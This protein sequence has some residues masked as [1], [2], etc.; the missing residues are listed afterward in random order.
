MGTACLLL[1]SCATT[2]GPLAAR[3]GYRDFQQSKT[4][5][6]VYF[7]VN[8]NT[9]ESTA[10][11]FFLT[12]AAQIA[13]KRG[14]PS[15]YIYHLKHSVGSQIYV[16]P[17]VTRTYIYRDIS[18]GYYGENGFFDPYVY[19]RR[20][21]IYQPPTYT[22]IE[23][24]GIRGQILLVRHRLKGEPPP[25][26]AHLLYREGMQLNKQVKVE[27]RRAGVAAVVGSVLVIG[28]AAVV[29]Y[30]EGGGTVYVGG[31]TY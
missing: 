30:F 31:A 14:Y 29:G 2:Y 15:F 1:A 25:F 5:Y 10:Y 8:Q 28:V 11:R 9:S 24:P 18:P 7:Y 27:N 6:Y 3:G 17:G 23:E 12:R 13:L 20:I 19:G 4:Q 26:D 16:T 22:R 21:T